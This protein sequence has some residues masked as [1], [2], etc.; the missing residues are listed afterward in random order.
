MRLNRDLA[1]GSIVSSRYW[2]DDQLVI[3]YSD[4]R[5]EEPPCVRKV[6]RSV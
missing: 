3:D 6:V 5:W 2:L 4:L 1:T